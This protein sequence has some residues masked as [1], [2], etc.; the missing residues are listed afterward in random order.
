M[1]QVGAVFPQTEIS[2]DPKAIE[3]YA[4]AVEEMGFDYILAYDH[5]LGADMTNRPDWKPLRGGP[6]AYTL[7]SMFHEPFVLFGYLAHVTK[8]VG[9]VSGVIILAQRQAAL[10]A[11]QAAEVDVLSGGRMRLGIG[12]G[13][14]HLEYDA[15][16]MNWRDRGKRSEEQIEV[17]RELWTKESVSYEGRWHTIPEMG[18]NPMPVQRPIPIWFGGRSDPLLDRVGRIGDGWFPN[19]GPK[20]VAEGLKKV[21]AAAEK[22]GPRPQV[23]R[24]GDVRG[25]HQ[26]VAGGGRRPR[27]A[28]E[29]PRPH[30]LRPQ[31]HGRRPP[32]RRRP[33]RR[34]PPLQTSPRTLVTPPPERPLLRPSHKPGNPCR[35]DPC[36]R[37]S[38]SPPPAIETRHPSPVGAS[39]DSPVPAPTTASRRRPP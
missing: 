34:P 8:R 4:V 5:V 30:P 25:D 14:N 29:G 37:P 39:R 32:W 13:W 17:M 31:H 9:L 11:K 16:D 23:D 2:A 24:S 1:L 7:D 28:L 10:V 18:L 3:A 36:G 35:G 20:Q 26:A 19:M 21:H 15:L 38:P 12:T 6:P 27:P 33:P 22:S